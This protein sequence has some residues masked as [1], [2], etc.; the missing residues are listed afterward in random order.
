MLENPF[1]ERAM[2]KEA[3]QFVG[4][5]REINNIL[6]RLR[7][8]NSVSLV[9][10][11]RIGKSSLLYYLFLTGNE[12]LSDIRKEKYH[13]L[14]FDFMSSTVKSPADFTIEICR[15]LGI[16]TNNEKIKAEPLVELEKKLHQYSLQKNLILLLDEFEKVI[17]RQELYKIDFFETLRSLCN[18]Q[19]LTIITASKK[20]LKQIGNETGLNSPFW[21]IFVSIPLAE[22]PCNENIDEVATFIKYY[23]QDKYQLNPDEYEKILLEVFKS[24]HPL[25]LQ[26][27][28]FWILQNRENKYSEKEL[29]EKIAE[30]LDSYF[31]N[32]K[33]KI[34]NWWASNLKLIP[35]GIDNLTDFLSKQVNKVQVLQGLISV[36]N[37]ENQKK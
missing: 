17:D 33:E 34:M 32:Q 3:E 35:K 16:E 27:I 29:G 19:K 4:R 24:T 25:A 1:T 37:N 10:D 18:A 8:G 23:W 7:T 14:Y 26:V 30:E 12:R 31:L 28:S 36:N 2:L 5:T 11:R 13:F 20:T 22:F 15:L 6:P 21:N 9:G